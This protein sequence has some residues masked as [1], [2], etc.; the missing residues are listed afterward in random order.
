MIVLSQESARERSHNYIGTEHLLLGILKEI[1]YRS[2]TESASQPE[3]Y[4]EHLGIA[5]HNLEKQ[6]D[7]VLGT[8]V[9]EPPEGHIPFTHRSKKVLELALREA[10][11]ANHNFIGPEHI[12]QG[13]LAEGEGVAFLTLKQ[14]GVGEE[15]GRDALFG[16]NRLR[17]HRRELGLPSER[18]ARRRADQADS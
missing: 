13:L 5:P 6:V 15:R 16:T 12:F 11:A 2:G 10:L 18:I 9:T 14:N 17:T 1:E 4:L 7:E 3:R 8:K